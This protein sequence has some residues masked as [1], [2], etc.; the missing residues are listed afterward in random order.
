MYPGEHLAYRQNQFDLPRAETRRHVEAPY[1]KPV[2]AKKHKMTDAEKEA[3][4]A[5]KREHEA[6]RKLQEE[7]QKRQEELAKQEEERQKREEDRLRH[8][9]D[10]R[11]H[12][13]E[14]RKKRLEE[15]GRYEEEER[16]FSD[17]EDYDHYVHMPPHKQAQ[18][19]KPYEYH[20]IET[21]EK[22]RKDPYIARGYESEEEDYGEE[23]PC[24]HTFDEEDGLFSE[25]E[26]DDYY[27]RRE[28]QRFQ[29]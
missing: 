25:S 4:E 29:N 2:K 20:D 14:E 26:D 11:R 9:E 7:Q 6:Q 27:D 15:T 13:E 28:K 19:A 10:D 5:V 8:E 17:E 16:H 18:R 22:A 3:K 1:Q 21:Q 23:L 12:R 24:H